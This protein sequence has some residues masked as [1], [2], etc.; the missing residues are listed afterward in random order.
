MPETGYTYVMKRT[1]FIYDDIFLRHEV[2]PGHPESPE[3]LKAIIKA[4]QGSHISSKLVYEKPRRAEPEE[5]EAVHAPEYARRMAEFT[6]YYD[7]DKRLFIATDGH[8]VI[9]VITGAS[10]RYVENLKRKKP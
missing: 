6:G 4:V 1:G 10:R 3:R 9:T 8:V 2:P 5:I 7:P